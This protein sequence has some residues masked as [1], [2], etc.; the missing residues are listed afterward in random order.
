MSRLDQVIA[1][2][3]KLRRRRL[4]L[5]LAGGLLVVAVLALSIL[6]P[7]PQQLGH[8]LLLSDLYSNA[9]ASE[10]PQDTATTLWE[11]DGQETGGPQQKLCTNYDGPAQN[12]SK[13]LYFKSG[14]QTAWY[15][16]P[17]FAGALPLM[18]YS[19]YASAP[20]FSDDI[21]KGAGS[22][23]VRTMLASATITDEQGRPLPDDASLRAKDEGA[24]DI[25]GHITTAPNN[26]EYIA[27]CSQ[28]MVHVTID[29]K[30]GLYNQIAVYKDSVAPEN[31][32]FSQSQSIKTWAV[33]FD[34]AL[35]QLQAA[36]FD[37]ERAKAESS[38]FTYAQL[39]NTQAGFAFSYAPSV[40]GEP[41]LT[42]L[43]N[44]QGQVTDYVYTFSG[45]PEVRMTVRT[46][47]STAQPHTLED[48]RALIDKRQWHIT[49]DTQGD[50]S[51]VPDCHDGDKEWFLGSQDEDMEHNLFMRTCGAFPSVYTEM[52]VA[53]RVHYIDPYSGYPNETTPLAGFDSFAP[54]GSPH[55]MH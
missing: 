55:T 5:A 6:R 2:V 46:A 7:L 1:E 51:H 44:G 54:G 34:Q 23:T 40:M 52:P 31:L 24:Y 29:A 36:G 49:T 48:M 12:P 27:D 11:V 18:R 42:E 19:E 47:L 28:L 26:K 3:R 15:S 16:Q 43:R 9:M 14:K 30:T 20:A 4:M 8:R 45:Q 32:S 41:K 22:D 33:S 25:Y 10:L 35:S 53:L 50:D 17:G 21:F 37:L 39:T 13:D 38:R